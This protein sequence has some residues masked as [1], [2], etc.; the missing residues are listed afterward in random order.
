MSSIAQTAST[1]RGRLLDEPCP[2]CWDRE[3]RCPLCL[4]QVDMSHDEAL[5]A[6]AL[7]LALAFAELGYIPEVPCEPERT[8]PLGWHADLGLVRRVA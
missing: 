7:R 5:Q 1:P 3:D 4:G 8:L 2:I 6:E